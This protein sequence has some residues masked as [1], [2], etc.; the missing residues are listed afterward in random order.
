MSIDTDARNDVLGR[1]VDDLGAPTATGHVVVGHRLGLY[2]VLADGPL[3]VT[4]LADRT[5]IRVRPVREWLHAQAALYYVTATD[6]GRFTLSPEQASYLADPDD[7]AGLAGAFPLEHGGI[8]L[9]EHDEDVLLATEA[10]R[11]PGYTANVTTK[12]IPALGD[13][14]QRLQ[15]G[16]RIADIGCRLGTSSIILAQAYPAARVSGS[17]DT[18]GSVEL[19]RRRAEKASVSDRVAFE[20]ASPATFTGTGFDLVTSFDC[21]HDTAD[22]AAAA[23]RVRAA[24]TPEGCWM[25][26]EPTADDDCNPVGR[27]WSLGAR[28]SL[29]AIR[30]VSREAGFTRCARVTGT[31]FNDVYAIRP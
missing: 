17:D 1:F 16:G 27:M 5:G 23:A 13:I 15:A 6:D 19:A 20:V 3:T 26:A 29:R 21:L 31:P 28:A 4:E 30:Q 14:E 25:L 12:W 11:R 8:G 7:P 24:I 18:E 2:R 10:F 9:P 22:P